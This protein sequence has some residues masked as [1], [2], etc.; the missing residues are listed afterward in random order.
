MFYIYQFKMSGI[1]KRKAAHEITCDKIEAFNSLPPEKIEE[2]QTIPEKE[3]EDANLRFGANS[4]SGTSHL[5]H[6][7]R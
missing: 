2:L 6:C 5:G 1:L 7:C 4:F 3:T